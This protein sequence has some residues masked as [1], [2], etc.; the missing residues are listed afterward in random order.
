MLSNESLRRELAANGMNAALRF[1]AH[2]MQTDVA[3]AKSHVAHSLG[4]DRQT[5][6]RWQEIGVD[7]TF[8]P[9]VLQIINAFRPIWSSY[10][11]APRQREVDI[12]KRMAVSG[13]FK[14]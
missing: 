14:G 13:R 11:L 7:E 2:H 4:I 3:Q 10:H 12:W 9:R 6:T 1:I 8:I 5:L